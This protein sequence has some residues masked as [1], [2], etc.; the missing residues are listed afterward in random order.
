[1]KSQ[2]EFDAIGHQLV[3]SIEAVRRTGIEVVEIGRGSCKLKMPLEGNVNHVNMMYAG[4]LFALAELM[5]G[6][7]F[8]GAFDAAKFYPV[9][10]EMNIKYARPALTDITT[11]YSL[12]DAEIARI[13]AEMD[14]RGKCIYILE[15]ELKDANGDVVAI[16]N[17]VYQGRSN[18]L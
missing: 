3:T 14:D 2:K 10:V 12:S 5:G 9:I 6:A 1:M 13:H 7:V 17:G 16:T 15:Q 4:S 8:F 18:K 11:E